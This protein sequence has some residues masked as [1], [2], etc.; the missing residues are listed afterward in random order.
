MIIIMKIITNTD[1]C[2]VLSFCVRIVQSER[3]LQCFP[4][5]LSHLLYEF[6]CICILAWLCLHV[7]PNSNTYTYIYS[8]CKRGPL[9]M[10]TS[11]FMLQCHS[12]PC[13][14]VCVLVC[15]HS[16]AHVRQRALGCFQA[17]QSLFLL[18][19]ILLEQCAGASSWQQ[20]QQ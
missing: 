1:V 14:C 6:N 17:T 12:H 8:I 4:S 15:I 16:C 13:L 5:L 20:H 9:Y 3:F 19:L 2:N 7:C 18:C 11:E 10:C